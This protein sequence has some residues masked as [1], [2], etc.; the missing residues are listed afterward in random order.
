MN[1]LYEY[2][3]W[4]KESYPATVDEWED[5]AERIVKSFRAELEAAWH[6]HEKCAHLGRTIDSQQVWVDKYNKAYADECATNVYLRDD[7]AALKREVE[8]LERI[9]AN[10]YPDG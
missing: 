1:P 7:N 5:W 10:N 3:Q 6:D 9:I 4:K 8:S 2:E